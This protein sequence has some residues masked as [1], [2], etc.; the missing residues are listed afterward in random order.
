M[1]RLQACAAAL[2]VLVA[3]PAGATTIIHAGRL[4]DGMSERALESVT[5]VVEGEAIAAVE[6]GYLPVAPGDRL[7]ELRDHTL[8]PGLMDLHVHLDHELSRDSYIDRFRWSEADYTLAAVVNAEKTLRAGFTTVRNLGDHYN[9]TVAVRDAI[10]RG[11][12]PGP[13]IYTA[14]KSIATTGGH[15]DPT[16]GWA[17]PL[18][19]D[20]GPAEG[21]V[22]GPAEARKAVR[23]RYKDGADLIKITATG[24]V[25]S[26]AKSGQNP[27]FREDE[28]VAIVE[29]ARDYGFRV[30][31]HAHGKEGMERAIRAGVY[32][33]EHGTY[34]DDET[35]A[36]MKQ[37]GTWYVPT[38]LAGVWVGEKAA[39]D[40]YFPEI[41]GP[42]AAAIGPQIRETFARAHA[43][44]VPIAFGTDSGVSPHGMNAREFTLMVEAGMSPMEAIRAATGV[45]AGFLGIDDRLGA[46]APGKLADL[47]AV[48]GDPLADIARMEQV[49]FVMKEGVVHLGPDAD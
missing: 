33:I 42:K 44:G 18:E 6:P 16:S 3:L 36:L 47:V 39:E 43:A 24:G 27:Q 21:V 35:M 37:H 40:G 25:L 5:V 34:M 30:A 23:Q 7:L 19:G 20:P 2:L 9:V 4:I 17:P 38:I 45:A 48:P 49:D 41:V 1:A 29:T 28:I 32:S 13:R 12:I 10:A 15:A 22:N 8:L 31:A 46:V 14:A 11:W 26:L